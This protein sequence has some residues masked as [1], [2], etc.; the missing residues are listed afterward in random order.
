MRAPRLA[1]AMGGHV[2]GAGQP[3]EYYYYKSSSSRITTFYWLCYAT[4]KQIG[5]SGKNL[6]P[7]ATGGHATGH[8]TLLVMLLV[9]LRY[10]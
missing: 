6:G 5:P 2:P 10:W 9:M 7:G 3:H 4:G 1:S 8:A